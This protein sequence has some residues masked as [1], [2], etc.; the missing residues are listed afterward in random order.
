MGPPPRR[1]RPPTPP[2]AARHFPRARPRRSALEFGA[3]RHAWRIGVIPLDFVLPRSAEPRAP[4]SNVA[5]RQ[6]RVSLS[7]PN[8]S[9]TGDGRAA[10]TAR[11]GASYAAYTP[12]KRKCGCHHLATDCRADF[13]LI[14]VAAVAGPKPIA[15]HATAGAAGSLANGHQGGHHR[16]LRGPRLPMLRPPSARKPARGKALTQTRASARGRDVQRE[17]FAGWTVAVC[18]A[19]RWP[20]PAGDG[21]RENVR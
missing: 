2:F 7:D 13:A 6:R 16:I 18:R 20:L 12:N 1:P 11:I 9:A 15:V 17:S 4:R 5:P 3:S 10:R 14:I 8:A 19:E 21:L